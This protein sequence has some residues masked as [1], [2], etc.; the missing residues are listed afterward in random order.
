MRRSSAIQSMYS[1]G[2]IKPKILEKSKQPMKC[3]KCY[4]ITM[5]E[6]VCIRCGHEVSGR[7][8]ISI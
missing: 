8:M 6:L 4:R 2:C 5:V 3:P 7:R 1:K